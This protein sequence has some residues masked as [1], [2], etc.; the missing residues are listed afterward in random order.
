M[1]L[2]FEGGVFGFCG[3]GFGEVRDDKAGQGDAS[4]IKSCF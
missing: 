2:D 4:V 3:V 1:W